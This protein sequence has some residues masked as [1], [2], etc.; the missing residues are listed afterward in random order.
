MLIYDLET[1]GLLKEVSVIWCAWTYDTRTKLYQGYLHP[2]HMYLDTSARPVGELWRDLASDVDG[3]VAHNGLGYDLEVLK[4]LHGHE[5]GFDAFYR[6]CHDE[7]GSWHIDTLILGRLL[8]P[9]VSS[10]DWAMYQSG[11]LRNFPDSP[12]ARQ[13][14][15]GNHNLAA[16]GYRLGVHKGTA[17]PDD[18]ETDWTVFQESYY[19]YNKQDVVV[20]NALLELFQK[21][22]AELERDECIELEHRFALYLE[23]QQQAGVGFDEPLATNRVARWKDE[24][25]RRQRTLKAS[26]PDILAEEEF[27]PKR[28][29]KTKG[30]VKGVPV[31]K[32]EIIPFKPTSNDHVI[33]FLTEKY[34]WQPTEFTKKKTPK[35]PMGKPQITH[36]ILKKLPYPEA[37]LLARIKLLTD[38]IGLL[39]SSPTAWLKCVADDGRIHGRIIHNGTPTSRCRHSSPN[40]GNVPS[41]KATWGRTLRA[42]YHAPDR[43]NQLTKLLVKRRLVGCDA[44]GLEMRILS[45]ALFPYDNG[46]FYRAAFDG[47][48]KDGTDCH[49]LNMV[50]INRVLLEAGLLLPQLNRDGAKT[51]FYAVLYGAFPKKV[52]QTFMDFTGADIPKQKMYAIG[53]LIMDALKEAVVGLDRLIEALEDSYNAAEEMGKWPHLYMP[54]GR[55][56]PVRSKHAILNTLC[57][58]TGSVVMKVAIVLFWDA[59]EEAGLS[60]RR[61]WDPVL[62][63]HDEI[64]IE[65]NESDSERIRELAERSIAEAGK[66]LR[67]NVPLVGSG[68]IGK[69]WADTH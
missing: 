23:H 69:T 63:V 47:S 40:L 61:D 2:D 33:F 25:A 11:K 29:N 21:K 32:R 17:G 44:D 58:T 16:W 50:A 55:P 37:P 68:A 7:I 26:V 66:L 9:D 43:W 64:Q 18:A 22:A 34:N 36:D 1:N 38:R 27:I 49:S 24:L 35:W 15:F 53:Q 57:Q 30:Y 46:S 42:M 62:F 31:M 20:T 59:C 3:I 5:P 14:L 67:F 28:D 41:T 45:N 60:I 4:K 13:K 51:V 12:K 10:M 8:F 54:D 6:K 65:C 52:A 19:T 56:A 39:S 48:K